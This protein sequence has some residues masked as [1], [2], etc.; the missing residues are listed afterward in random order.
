M[1]IE[2]EGDTDGH[3]MD[4]EGDRVLFITGVLLNKNNKIIFKTIY[5]MGC[6]DFPCNTSNYPKISPLYFT[7][8][9]TA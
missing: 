8:S 1:F 5:E 2:G 4:T 9:G 3:V 7:D 6:M